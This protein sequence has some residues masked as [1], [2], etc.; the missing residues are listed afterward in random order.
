MSHF[1][2][3]LIASVRKKSSCLVVGLD[4]CLERL[5]GELKVGA[6]A[7]RAAA[8]DALLAFNVQVL[9]AT[10]DY[11]AAVKPQVAFYERLGWEGFR[12]FERTVRTAQ[13]MGLPVIADMKRG[14]IGSTAA[15]YA[16]ACFEEIGADAVTVNAYLGSDGV[17]PFLEYVSAGKGIYVLVKTSNP[18]SRE[19]QDRDAGGAKVYERMAELVAE[20]GADSIGESGYSAVGAVVG[21]T[22]PEEV[23]RLRGLMP[24]TPLLLPGY[25]AQGASAEDCRPAFD[26]GGLGAVVNSSRGIIF[27]YEKAAPGVRW[28]DAVRAAACRAREDLEAVRC[29]DP[30][31]ERD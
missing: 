8:A 18:S 5:P 29:A 30:R 16:Q 14:D 19:L 25:G 9:E 22:Y 27:A 20:W 31:A 13:E 10:A 12:A 4:P 11:I 6:S 28:Q 15:A 23:A 3:R 1:A 24:G 2:D 26:A 17:R 21:A 7:S